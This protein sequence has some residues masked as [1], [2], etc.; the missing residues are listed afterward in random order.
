MD[1]G[2]VLRVGRAVYVGRS[3]RTNDDGIAQLR[4][5]LAPLGYVARPVTVNGC[6]HLKSACCHV[7]GGTLLLSRD[8]ID[9]DSL[10]DDLDLIDVHPDEPDG[11][12]ALLVGDT[13]VHASAFPRTRDRLVQRGFDVRPLDMSELSKAEGGVTCC[14]VIFEAQP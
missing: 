12:N 7:G 2:D 14:S 1:G 10:G 3:G 9:A 11:A 8:R 13:V 6:L 4:D 5:I